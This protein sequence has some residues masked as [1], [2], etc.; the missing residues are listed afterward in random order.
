MAAI[1]LSTLNWENGGAVYKAASVSTTNQEFKL[2]KWCKLITVQPKSQAIYFSYEGTDG[3][4]PTAN[5]FPQVVD[6]IIQYNPQQSSQQRS[7]FIASQAG[8]AT[9]YLIFE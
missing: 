3:A 5:A 9:L 4:A 2:P 7:V 1:D 8:T 6:S